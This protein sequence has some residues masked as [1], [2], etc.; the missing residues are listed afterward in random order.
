MLLQ[1]LAQPWTDSDTVPIAAKLSGVAESLGI[2]ADFRRAQFAMLLTALEVQIGKI[3][4]VVEAEDTALVVSRLRE[5]E[6]NVK[7]G[8]ECQ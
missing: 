3:V 8:Q 5:S 6:R 4:T 1:L 7:L 2:Q